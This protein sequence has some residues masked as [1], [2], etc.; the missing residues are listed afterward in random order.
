MYVEHNCIDFGMDEQ[1]NPGEGVV[2]GS[3]TINGLLVYVFS[4]EFT[5][6]GGAVSE[7]HAM[8]ICKIM[9]IAMKVGAPGRPS[10]RN[11]AA[12]TSP[13]PAGASRTAMPPRARAGRRA[14]RHRPVGRPRIVP[15]PPGRAG[16][17]GGKRR[18]VDGGDHPPIFWLSLPADNAAARV[19][20]GSRRPAARNRPTRR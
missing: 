11:W 19:P 4:Q 16:K 5:V 18:R 7:R 6:Y 1:H 20:C 2:T 14:A 12:A 8:K 3:C 15:P 10:T 13:V 9:D 17:P